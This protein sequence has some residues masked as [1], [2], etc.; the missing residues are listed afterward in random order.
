[1]GQKACSDILPHNLA[2]PHEN[3]RDAQRAALPRE[4]ALDL[5]LTSCHLS[6]LEPRPRSCKQTDKN[7]ETAYGAH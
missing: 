2:L 1:M 3:P 5:P 4:L 6:V 7:D